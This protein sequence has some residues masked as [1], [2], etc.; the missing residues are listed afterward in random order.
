MS[1]CET[2][3]C[4]LFLLVNKMDTITEFASREQTSCLSTSSLKKQERLPTSVFTKENVLPDFSKAFVSSSESIILNNKKCRKLLL[5]P[6]SEDINFSQTPENGSVDSFPPS[7]AT[8]QWVPQ[9]PWCQKETTDIFKVYK[10]DCSQTSNCKKS[11]KNTKKYSTVIPRIKSYTV[12]VVHPDESNL[13]RNSHKISTLQNNKANFS[14]AFHSTESF[15]SSQTSSHSQLA[16]RPEKQISVVSSQNSSNNMLC[17]NSHK[18]LKVRNETINSSKNCR[19]CTSEP[20]N[21]QF[22]DYS[23][24]LQSYGP[25]DILMLDKSSFSTMSSRRCSTPVRGVL[26]RAPEGD[27]DLSYIIP[28][29]SLVVDS[30]SVSKDTE[31]EKIQTNVN[32][33]VGP[34]PNDN[35][36]VGLSKKYQRSYNEGASFLLNGNGI[37]NK[38]LNSR[39]VSCDMQERNNSKN[40]AMFACY[41]SRT[42][43]TQ[44]SSS[45]T[46]SFVTRTF[47][48]QDKQV[49]SLAEMSPHKR[50]SVKIKKINYY[51]L[52]RQPKFPKFDKFCNKNFYKYLLVKMEN[53]YGIKTNRKVVELAKKISE[54]VDNI[55]SVSKNE[56]TVINNFKTLLF[57]KKVIRT[58]I[59][60]FHFCQKFLPFQFVSKA[61]PMIQPMNMPTAEFDWEKICDPI[62]L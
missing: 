57:R 51:G 48:K 17:P 1:N 53:K 20:E 40:D 7:D 42:N 28:Y 24:R 4:S 6:N 8:S 37:K 39:T 45:N 55:K 34:L 26:Q 32:I 47:H 22:R 31:N 62:E 38:V 23:G 14:E 41:H 58:H 59:E 50:T 19:H 21:K 3:R 61:V 18:I 43:S 13:H 10:M 25:S 27:L 44:S 49:N 12:D 36:P 56:K 5:C 35:I 2:G 54:I 11:P 9:T 52:P 15:F 46:L 33:P 16:I 30:N 29:K 60:F